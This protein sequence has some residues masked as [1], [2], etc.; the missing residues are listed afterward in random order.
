MM[1]ETEEIR[2]DPQ[3]RGYLDGSAKLLLAAQKHE[4]DHGPNDRGLLDDIED[5]I[6]EIERLLEA[7]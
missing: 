2:M 1:D 7:Y 4:T 6:V 3:S 5:M